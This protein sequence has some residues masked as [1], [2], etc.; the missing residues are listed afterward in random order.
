M[1]SQPEN[2]FSDDKYMPKEGSSITQNDF[3][4]QNIEVYT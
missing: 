2:S 4:I 1:L 3:R